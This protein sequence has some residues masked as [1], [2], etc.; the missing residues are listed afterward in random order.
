M[1]IMPWPPREGKAAWSGMTKLDTKDGS[2]FG[3]TT[4]IWGSV[5]CWFETH[6]DDSYHVKDRFAPPQEEACSETASCVATEQTGNFHVTKVDNHWNSERRC[7]A[8]D[9]QRTGQEC[10]MVPVANSD[11]C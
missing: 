11:L 9:L 1:E 7:K 4:E 10:M 8:H 6:E 3:F 5:E 2:L